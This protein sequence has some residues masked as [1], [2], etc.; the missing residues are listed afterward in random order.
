M[1]R[2]TWWLQMVGTAGTIFNCVNFVKLKQELS[3]IER[4]FVSNSVS[5]YV[6]IILLWEVKLLARKQV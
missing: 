2:F 4:A 5:L 1:K 3:L 6:Y